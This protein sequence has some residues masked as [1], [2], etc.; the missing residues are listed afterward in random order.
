MYKNTQ[1]YALNLLGRGTNLL[2]VFATAFLVSCGSAISEELLFRGFVF[3]ALFLSFHDPIVALIG[4]SLTFGILHYQSGGLLIEFIVGSVYGFS[5]ILSG[6]NM[7]VPIAVHAFY[8]CGT[9]LFTYMFVSADLRRRFLQAVNA[10]PSDDI[11]TDTVDRMLFSFFDFDGDGY[12]DK[13]E[14]EFGLKVFEN[15]ITLANRKALNKLFENIDINHDGKINFIEFTKI[16]SES[17][18]QRV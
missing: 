1:A 7:V 12:I 11:V 2:P 8:D 15:D 17:D 9:L 6:Y 18:K 16:V 5:Y 14:L 13:E 4:S 3:Q 10:N